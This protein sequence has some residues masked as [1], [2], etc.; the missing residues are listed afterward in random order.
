MKRRSLITIT[1]CVTLMTLIG[2]A[3]MAGISA[4]KSEANAFYVS[5]K[6]DDTNPGTI[7][8]PFK[9]LSRAR[10]AVRDYKARMRQLPQGELTVFLQ[11]GDYMLTEPLA[12]GPE[13]SGRATGAIRWSG[14]RGGTSRLIGGKIVS[15][16]KPVS[17]PSA[18]ARIKQEY[19]QHILQ[20]DLRALAISDFSVPKSELFFK[21]RYMKLAR[22]PNEDWLTIKDVPQHGAQV[23]YEGDV[24]NLGATFNGIPAGRHWGRFVYEGERPNQWADRD[25]IWMRGFWCWDWSYGYQKVHRFDKAKNE[26]Y[27]EEPYHN[28][29]YRRGQRFAFLNILEELDAPGE[30]YIDSSTGMLYFWPPQPIRPGDVMFPVMESPMITLSGTEYVTIE[31]LRLA[32][33]RG[34]AISM[35]GGTGNLIAG[36]SFTNICDTVVTIDEGT[37]NGIRSCDIFEVSSS[38]IQVTGGDRTRLTPAYNFAVNNYVHHYSRSQKSG[39]TGVS[40]SGVGN[41]MANNRVHDAPHHAIGSGGNDNI[42]EYN[43]IHDVIKETGDAGAIHIGRDWTMRGNK[44][45]FNYWHHIRG[46]KLEGPAFTSAIS[47]YLDDMWSGTLVYGNI[48]FDCDWA[49]LI[50]GGHDNT[51]E[52]NIMAKCGLGF[53]G[54]RRSLSW[55]K[56]NF[57][58]GGNA[59]MWETLEAMPYKQE[60]WLSKY[61]KLVN[62][63]DNE[64]LIPK[65]NLIIRNIFSG[66]TWMRMLDG[67][68]FSNYAVKD[69]V[70]SAENLAYWEYELKG[71]SVRIPFGD[72][73]LAKQLESFGNILV[74]GNPGFIDPANGNLRLV[75]TAPAL[76]LGFKPIPYDKIG[77][78]VDEW[79]TSLPSGRLPERERQ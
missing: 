26:V 22:Y 43:E 66:N 58:K 16:F 35:K 70:I 10:D 18:L 73:R 62:I 4:Q 52:N 33:S 40:V 57:A 12:L 77:L 48:F 64:P 36:C 78:F 59:H 9:T 2:V 8:K 44:I 5:P 50:G 37:N 51:V 74:E 13:D 49:V 14:V 20:A 54:D 41:R 6:G 72:K 38:G 28:Y 71:D 76:N 45:Q 15:D 24:Q 69:N 17:E 56:L 65:G 30:W 1:W 75:A 23:K 61:P 11:G 60:P 19:R 67:A 25:D 7:D 32:G 3:V 27:P 29:G 47:V 39:T 42:I 34:R 21:G 46:P 31:N 68:D 55:G 63:L 79:R 53:S